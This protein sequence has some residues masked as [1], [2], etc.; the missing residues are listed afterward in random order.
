[1]LLNH[2]L[3]LRAEHVHLASCLTRQTGGTVRVNKIT[4]KRD[5]KPVAFFA[6]DSE[7]VGLINVWWRP[8]N[9]AQFVRS[10]R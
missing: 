10:R 2:F 5:V 9:S 8:A 3:K 4:A 1:M 7:L 6:F